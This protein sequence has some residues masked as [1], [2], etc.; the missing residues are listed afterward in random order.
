M[1]VWIDVVKLYLERRAEPNRADQYGYTPLHKASR[2]GYK[3]VTQVLLDNG[4][5]INLVARD[6]FTPLG[7]AT[8]MGHTDI[9]NLLRKYGGT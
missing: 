8:E 1:M 5:E 2:Y 4:V 6:G 7:S 3:D 9:V